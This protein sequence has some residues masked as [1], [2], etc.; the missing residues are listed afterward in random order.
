MSSAAAELKPKHACKACGK[1]F[2]PE[3]GQEICDECQSRRATLWVIGL[4]LLLIGLILLPLIV[5][6]I[7]PPPP[8]P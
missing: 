4:A 2:D 6:L 3:E 8:P 1:P 7:F 5:P